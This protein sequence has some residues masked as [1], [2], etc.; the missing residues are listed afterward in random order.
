MK[1]KYVIATPLLAGLVIYLI[2][3][4]TQNTT[5]SGNANTYAGS[6]QFATINPAHGQPGHRCD[7][8]VGAPLPSG[9]A[10]AVPVVQVSPQISIN[11]ASPFS[12]VANITNPKINPAHGEPGHRCDIAVG[13][14]LT[15]T[16]AT[17]ASSQAFIPQPSAGQTTALPSTPKPKA[18][19]A[20]GQ[21]WHRCDLQVGAPLT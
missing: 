20:H 12:P 4:K 21:P 6:P 7:I 15:A 14:P 2:W 16:N 1:M 3:A 10:P 17:A 9:N 5:V 8:A 11:Q 19:P 18:N 13:A